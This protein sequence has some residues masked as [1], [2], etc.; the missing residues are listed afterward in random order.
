MAAKVDLI[1]LSYGQEEYTIRCMESIRK[2]TED[3]RLVW[4]DN[5]SST[6]SRQAVMEE[7][8]KHESRLTIWPS[9]NL[10]FVQGVNLA[11]E[12]LLKNKK[13]QAEYIGILN[14]DIE[15]TESWLDKCVGVMEKKESVGAVGPIS[16]AASS[17]QGWEEVFPRINIP[18]SHSLH[19]MNTE[20]RAKLLD[21]EFGD[22]CAEA[23][24]GIKCPMVAF[25]CTIFRRK[26]FEEVGRL[27]TAYGVGYGDDDDFCRRMYQANWRVAVALGSYVFHNHRTTFSANYESEEVRSLRRKNKAIY[28]KKFARAQTIERSEL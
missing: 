4:L 15:V 19:D 12:V 9:E 5:A 1:V 21:K 28:D 2:H 13:I 18:F 14:N 6:E 23:P 26:V 7:F 11:V 17:I 3:Y 25:F 16:S 27:D 10:G 20:E 22:Q 8:L 24:M